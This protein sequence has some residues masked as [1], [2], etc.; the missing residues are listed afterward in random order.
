MKSSLVI[1]LKTVRTFRQFSRFVTAALVV[2]L[3]GAFAAEAAEI[4]RVEEDWELVVS[5]PD[6][7]NNAPQVTCVMSPAATTDSLHM[8]LEINHKTMPDYEPG[9]VQLQVWN[10]ETPVT[11]KN[12]PIQGVLQSAAETVRWTTKMSLADGLLTFE[13]TDGSST[14]WGAFG[15]QGYLKAS[16]PTSATSLLTYSP[17]SSRSKSGVGFAANRVE[18]LVIKE[19]RYY[20]SLGLVHKD[21]TQRVVS[22]N[23]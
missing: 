12:S 9:G 21:T 23:E 22:S 7:D 17:E 8:A 1:H 3:T 11:S 10:G 16:V 4:V 5:E 18:T 2:T 14:S 6:P 19:V 13:I 15:G 20:S